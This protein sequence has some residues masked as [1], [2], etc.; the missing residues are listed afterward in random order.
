MV[1]GAQIILKKIEKFDLNPKEQQIL[2]SAYETWM[3]F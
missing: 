2:F 3:K 1:L